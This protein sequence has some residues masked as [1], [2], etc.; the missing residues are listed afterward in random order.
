MKASG[1]DGGDGDR[2]H[3]VSARMRFLTKHS[4]L[5]FARVPAEGPALPPLSALERVLIFWA[6]M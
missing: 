1:D 2:W 3:L 6:A 5:Y 4:N